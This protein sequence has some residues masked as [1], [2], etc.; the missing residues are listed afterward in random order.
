MNY[1]GLKAVF[2]FCYYY[3][4]RCSQPAYLPKLTAYYFPYQDTRKHI[5]RLIVHSGPGPSAYSIAGVSTALHA[6]KLTIRRQDFTS[7]QT[8]R[9]GYGGYISKT[10][11]SNSFRITGGPY[12]QASYGPTILF[13]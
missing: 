5:Q 12:E 1:A 6:D 7:H 3:W 11:L 10:R 4:N 13:N 9:L 8:R 2:I